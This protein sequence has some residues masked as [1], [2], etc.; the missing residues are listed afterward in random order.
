MKGKLILS[1]AEL[2]KA[3][4]V[5]C[6]TITNWVAHEMPCRKPGGPGRKS[7]FHFHDV[8]A[9]LYKYSSFEF[10]RYAHPDTVIWEA[11]QRAQAIVKAR[12]NRG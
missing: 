3:F 8:E 5:S 6:N 9:W 4:N 12:N 7:E 2:A 1:R 11:Y 10:A